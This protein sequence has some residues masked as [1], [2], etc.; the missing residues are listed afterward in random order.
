MHRYKQFAQ[1][2]NKRVICLNKVSLCLIMTKPNLI[3]KFDMAKYP[4][5][6]LETFL[7]FGLP[8]LVGLQ[9]CRTDPVWESWF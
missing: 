7:C 6:T 9:K 2:E 4:D 3:A 1:S 5:L 8:V